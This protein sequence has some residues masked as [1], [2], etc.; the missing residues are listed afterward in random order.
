MKKLWLLLTLFVL[1]LALVACG[2]EIDTETPD[3]VGPE[4]DPASQDSELDSET[5]PAGETEHV[6]DLEVDEKAATCAERGYRVETCK[7]CGEIVVETAYP[8]Q[9]C[10][11]SGD[12]TCDV[13]S[14]C[15]MCGRVL[16]AAKGHVFGE[17]QIVEASCSAP[18]S[19]S[20][21]CTV[22]GETVS[23]E[24]P[25]T[26]DY[27]MESFKLAADGTMKGTC[28]NCGEVDVNEEVRVALDFNNDVET[29]LAAGAYGSHLRLVDSTKSSVYKKKNAV[30][31]TNEDRTVLAPTGAVSIDFDAELLSDARYYVIS[32]DYCITTV[33]EPAN[34]SDPERATVIALLPGFQ[35]GA[36]ASAAAFQWGNFTK[37]TFGTGWIYS[38]FGKT[39]DLNSGAKMYAPNEGEWYTLTYI[40]DNVEG[41]AY[42]YVNGEFVASPKLPKGIFGVN[43]TSAEKY[44]G[45]F[46]LIFADDYVRKYNAQFDSF[47]I[48]VVR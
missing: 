14:V 36:Q 20:G 27:V 32:F 3:A 11:S 47:E 12:A 37:Y 4:N 22:C 43:A 33:P 31:G 10:I 8:K 16:E 26:H 34:P 5:D 19:K 17:V 21:S 30:I 15:T 45:Y 25:V 39:A 48:S 6:H 1:I 24:I 42:A 41:V 38:Q 46:S 13:D 28:K 2:G 40:V 18:G 7:T 35:N 44:E 9:Q 23:E 29:E